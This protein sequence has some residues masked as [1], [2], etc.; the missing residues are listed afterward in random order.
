MMRSLRTFRLV[1]A[2]SGVV[3]GLVMT[4]PAHAAPIYPMI[5]VTI[6][7]R[8]GQV[9]TY[10]VT[11]QAP[12]PW[13]CAQ[14]QWGSGT[15]E[16]ACTPPIAPAGF[17]NTCIWN[18]VAITS[19]GIPLAGNL[20]AQANCDNDP[21]ASAATP[22]GTSNSGAAVVNLAFTTFYCRV[23][24]GAT[25]PSTRPWTATCTDNH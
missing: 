8:A 17:T 6:T 20:Y 25:E 21:G 5:A 14:G 15:Y 19:A 11:A 13:T 24:G 23:I 7:A 2:A 16:V 4:A 3:T 9:P 12:T 18:A 10:T 22:S 1:L